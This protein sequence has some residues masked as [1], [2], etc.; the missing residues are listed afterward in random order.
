MEKLNFKEKE[1]K[2]KNIFERNKNSVNT[3]FTS[4]INSSSP[5]NNNIKS[6]ILSLSIAG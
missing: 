3:Y 1:N 4:Y 2:T 6:K 5:H